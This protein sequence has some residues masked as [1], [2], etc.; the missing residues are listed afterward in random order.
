MA[1]KK[2]KSRRLLFT[3][4]L[5][6]VIIITG[7][8]KL[9]ITEPSVVKVSEKNYPTITKISMV[10]ATQEATLTPTLTDTPII[11]SPTI[12]QTNTPLT[13]AQETEVFQSHLPTMIFETLSSVNSSLL[14]SI[15][16][17]PTVWI[18][19]NESNNPAITANINTNCR[20]GPAGHYKVVGALNVG[21]VSYVYGKYIEGGWWYIE[22]I[23]QSSPKFCWVWNDTTNVF[24]DPTTIP[25]IN[26]PISPRLQIDTSISVNPAVSITCPVKLDVSGSISS[27]L[28]GTVSYEIIDEDGTVLK[29][30]NLYFSGAKTLYVSYSG[31]I[32]ES[33]TGWYRL[34]IRYPLAQKSNVASFTVTC[35]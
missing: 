9:S 6:I 1:E 10:D 15:E 21:E 7:C 5:L 26:V 22:N 11:L 31:K 24:G 12:T 34:I 16:V 8:S 18:P 30:G 17:T 25:I 4:L 19:P 35:P 14:Q 28:S 20:S 3:V 33:R 29:S 23:S 27:N 13:I 32:K 2:M